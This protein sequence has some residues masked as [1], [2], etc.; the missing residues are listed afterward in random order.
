MYAIPFGDTDRAQEI[1][2]DFTD[3]TTIQEIKDNDKLRCGVSRSSI[4]SGENDEYED[5]WVGLD[6]DFCRGLA[7]ALF[8]GQTGK[9]SF[10]TLSP[11]ERFEALQSRRVHV[12]A[13]VTTITLERDVKEPGTGAGLA[14][15][16]PNFHDGVRFAGE[17]E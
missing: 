14:F 3:S 17:P 5:V 11:S 2:P 12:L 6:A 10:V 7:A 13:S 1:A 8:D 16:F 9:V 4:F 15:A